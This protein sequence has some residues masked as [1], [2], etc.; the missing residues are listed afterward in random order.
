[1]NKLNKLDILDG[2]EAK[3]KRIFLKLKLKLK[4]KKKFFGY[5]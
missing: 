5:F 2:L 3:N 4:L 1:M